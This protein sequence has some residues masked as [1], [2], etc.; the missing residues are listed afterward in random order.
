M[1]TN[2]LLDLLLDRAPFADV[3][4]ELWEANRV[5]RFVA[6][7]S[8]IAPPTLY[9]VGRRQIGAAA[10]RQGVADILIALQVCPVDGEVLLAALGLPLADFEDAVQHASASAAGMEA[11]VTRDPD[12]FAGATL[13]VLSPAHFLALLPAAGVDEAGG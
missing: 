6:Y 8:A 2:V 13:P 7:I 10:A 12:G 1:D 11:I 9:Y 3:A 5:G 4:A